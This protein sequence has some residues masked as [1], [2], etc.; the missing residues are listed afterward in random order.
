MRNL[1]ATILVIAGVITGSLGC[2]ASD[3]CSHVGQPVTFAAGRPLTLRVEGGVVWASANAV[4]DVS[5]AWTVPAR[6]PV[7]DLT[8][9]ALPEGGGYVVS[10]RQ[11]GVAWRGELDAHR[12]PR[13]PLQTTSEPLPMAPAA[14]RAVATR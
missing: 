12:A 5:H 1:A 6:G 2:A 10:F 4:S 11:G 8:V 7:D 13:G 14:D 9:S 3:A